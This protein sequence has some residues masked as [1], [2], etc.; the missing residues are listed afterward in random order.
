MADRG[1]PAQVVYPVLD[2][3][4]K[5][6]GI[7][8]PDELAILRAEPD[9]QALVNAADLMRQAVAVDVDDD[10]G[11][12]LQTMIANGLSQLPIT[13]RAGR[14]VGF[15]TEGDIARAYQRLRTSRTLPDE[16]E[17]QA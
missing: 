4:G 6:A 16:A 5:I 3:A 13:D 10:L 7:I 14:C 9:L 17:K 11:F 12:A 1:K 2:E 8:T 15:V